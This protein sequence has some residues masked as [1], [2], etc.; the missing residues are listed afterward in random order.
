[1]SPKNLQQQR[2][3]LE[4]VQDF[5]CETKISSSFFNFHHL[6]FSFFHFS[7]LG[8]SKSVFL[9]SI[10]SR[11]LTTFLK[12]NRAVS[13]GTLP[14]EV[15]FLCFWVCHALAGLA[16]TA[17]VF[18]MFLH[19]YWASSGRVGQITLLRKFENFRMKPILGET[20]MPLGCVI[21]E[22]GGNAELR[23]WKAFGQWINIIR[24]ALPVTDPPEHARYAARKIVNFIQGSDTL[25]MKVMDD[26]STADRWSLVEESTLL[27]LSFLK[28]EGSGAQCYMLTERVRRSAQR[29]LQKGIEYIRRATHKW[30][31]QA[32][33]GGA[34]PAHRWCGKEDALPDLPLV[35]RDNQGHFTTD[36]QSVAEHYAK[37]W[38][39]EWR[40]VDKIGF[41]KETC[42][43]CDLRVK[44]V[45]E[46]QEW[47]RNLDLSATS[48]HKACLS[49]PSKTAIGLD[50]HAFKDIAL[51][52]DNALGSLGEIIRQCFVKLAIPTQSPLQL[53]VLLGKKM[54]GAEPSPSCTQHTVS[55][56]DW[57]QHTSV[58]GMSISLESGA[59]HSRVIQLLERMLR[60][61]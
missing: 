4:T 28:R 33:K 48:I 45:A 35:I 31:S 15:F 14:F 12:K 59:L 8:L 42:S 50:Q 27:V 54:E 26:L 56:C 3:K 51:L 25:S 44:H 10:A 29:A 11:F 19:S 61:P 43:I 38:K 49:F 53:L 9:A 13:G 46:A 41:D 2:R 57:Y 7:Y 32:L 22:G 24:K 5:A 40:D 21:L 58:N 34:G 60:G 16:E 39:R 17:F 30:L 52:P 37:E 47:A 23:A 1:M 55:P 6:F 20:F 36:P 18:C